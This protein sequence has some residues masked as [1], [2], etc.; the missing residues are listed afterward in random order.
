MTTIAYDVKTGVIATDSQETG[1]AGQK[2]NC[3][4]LY[5]IRESIIA[6]SGGTYAGLAFVNWF[7]DWE[8][9][10]DWDDHPDFINLD[11]EEDFECLVICPNE[12]YTVNRLFVPA[13]QAGNRFIALG[14]GGQAA[15]A[16]MMQGATPKEAVEIAKK[17]DT[18][19]GGKV[20][21]MTI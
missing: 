12:C 2:Y 3:K 7:D 17:I 11:W 1:G 21:E 14:S 20:I 18:Y 16:A 19:T 6:T 8:G 13:D 9:D 4:K 15:R 5:R 10:P